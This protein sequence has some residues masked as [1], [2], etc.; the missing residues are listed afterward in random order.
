MRKLPDVRY[1]K[2][3]NVEIGDTILAISH[4]QYG[5]EIM[6]K[7]IV[8]SREHEGSDRVYYTKEGAVI[9]RW[10]M[11]LKPRRVTLLHRPEPVETMLEMF[12]SSGRL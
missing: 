7:G 5:V 8:A 11:S 1:I 2:P 4:E 6:R 9:M 12:E 10:N 3:E